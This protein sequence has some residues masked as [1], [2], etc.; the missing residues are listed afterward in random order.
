MFVHGPGYIKLNLARLF[1]RLLWEPFLYHF[2][3]SHGLRTLKAQQ[4]ALNGVDHHHSKQLFS[5]CSEAVLE[6]LLVPYIRYCIEK[7]EE[8]SNDRYQDW[9]DNFVDDSTYTLL[10]HAT[11]TYLLGLH[12]YN[13][14][15][16]INHDCS[17]DHKKYQKLLLR[18]LCQ[19]VQMLQTLMNYVTRHERFSVSGEKNREGADF[20]H[21]NSNKTTK[22]FLPPGMPTT[23]M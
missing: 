18:N 7:G 5:S 15:T 9:V 16:K 12:L 6:E 8:T 23:K 10:Y 11:F 13:E 19:L 21:E 20:V 4:V 14:A 22:S 1:L 2:V 17:F 3:K